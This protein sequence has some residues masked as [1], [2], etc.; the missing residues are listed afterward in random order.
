MSL[1]WFWGTAITPIPWTFFMSWIC[2]PIQERTIPLPNYVSP[3]NYFERNN[4]CCNTIL[5]SQMLR[6]YLLPLTI[7]KTVQQRI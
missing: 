5:T 1:D 2:S 6:K 3:R 7:M 4:A